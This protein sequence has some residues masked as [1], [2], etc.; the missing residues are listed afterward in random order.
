MLDDSKDSNYPTADM[1]PL[2]TFTASS[3]KVPEHESSIDTSSNAIGT[4]DVNNEDE[5]ASGMGLLLLVISLMLGMF[6]V[7]LDNVRSS[8]PNSCYISRN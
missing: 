5:Y 1:A 8:L 2:P 3:E 4:L 6:L 7:A